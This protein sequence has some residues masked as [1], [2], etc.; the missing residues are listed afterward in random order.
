MNPSRDTELLK[1]VSQGG[2][3]E[4]H[5]DKNVVAVVTGATQGLGLALA[6]G[7]AQ[8]LAPEDIVYLTGRDIRRVQAATEQ[9]RRP[10][11]EL[12]GH[13]LDV[14]DGAAVQAFADEIESRHGGVDIIFSNAAARLTPEA[15]SAELVG[16]FVNTNNLGTTRM[17]HSFHPILRG[18]GRLLVVASDFG[19]LRRLL[20]AC[21][22]TSTLTPCHSTTSTPLCRPGATRLSRDEMPTRAGPAGSTSRRRW[23]KWLRCAALARS[24]SS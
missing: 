15:S 12:R 20:P 16:P 10:R 1:E 3:P 24:E 23:T 7:L 9:V 14:G 8:R 5:R 4:Q 21:T 13:L 22:V 11:A 6:E 19:S 2:P 17:L 18:G